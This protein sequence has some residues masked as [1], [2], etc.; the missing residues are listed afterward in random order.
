MIPRQPDSQRR[1]LLLATVLCALS[2]CAGQSPPIADFTAALATS[3][4]A[5]QTS[6][7]QM[8]AFERDYYLQ[9]AK[10]KRQPVALRDEQGRPTPLLGT[11]SA[12]SLKARAD[13]LA[14]LNAYAGKLAALAASTAP[15][16]TLT[17]TQSL[18]AGL[19]GL[20]GT[21]TALANT[22][23]TTAA[24][25]VAPVSTI[26]GWVGQQVLEAKRDAAIS[27]A[28]T[29]AGPSV[30]KVLTLLQQ[31]LHGIQLLQE[32]GWENIRVEQ[33]RYL[34][35]NIAKMPLS[36]MTGLITDIEAS[37]DA[38]AQA[39]TFTP[40]T[41]LE[42]TQK[43]NTALVTYVSSPHSPQDLAQLTAALQAFTANVTPLM[44]TIA[45]LRQKS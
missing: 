42:Q 32:T 17:S 18:G 13:A 24:S 23:D 28:I 14:L 29:Q 31:D 25:Y 19:V 33:I 22:S 41:L 12:T 7:Q 1:T 10:Y 27:A 35:A 9:Q 39:A 38:I 36:E 6:F 34:D 8:N 5:A 44:Q 37:S 43:A 20:A 3:S 45:T 4:A 40:L 15:A 2:A 21:F 11:F 30:D 16:Q 26:L